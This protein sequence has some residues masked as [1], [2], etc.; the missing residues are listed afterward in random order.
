ML[1]LLVSHHLDFSDLTGLYNGGRMANYVF[2]VFHPT[3]H[4]P[5]LPLINTHTHMHV[6]M[7]ASFLLKSSHKQ[8]Q[9]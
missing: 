5:Q 9:N 3:P 6:C 1:Y 2:F 4:H 8:A 7:C